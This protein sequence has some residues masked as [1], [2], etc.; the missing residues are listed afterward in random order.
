[1]VIVIVTGL[2]SFNFLRTGS[3]KLVRSEQFF[4]YGR[5]SVVTIRKFFTPCGKK[6]SQWSLWQ[7][8]VTCTTKSPVYV[9]KDAIKITAE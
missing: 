2:R 4:S 8:I 5:I 6:M 9:L 7:K 3:D 1:L